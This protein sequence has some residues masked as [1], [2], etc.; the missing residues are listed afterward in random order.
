M[1]KPVLNE[2]LER[3][4]PQAFGAIGNG[5]VDDTTALFAAAK[6]ASEKGLVLELDGE[7]L[8]SQTL[9]LASVNVLSKNA[10]LVYVGE[11]KSVPA[12]DMIRN[13]NV[14]GTL[15]IDF[16]DNGPGNHGGRCAMGF[17]H[18]G[19]GRGGYD[20][21]VEHVVITG[22]QKDANG[23]LITGDSNNILFD[24][25]TV[26]FEGSANIGRA[27]LLH[28]GNANDHRVIGQWS[29]ENGYQHVDGWKPTKHPHNVR[30]GVLECY[31][32]KEQGGFGEGAFHIAAGYDV[33]LDELI[34]DGFKHAVMITG[35]DIGFEY[36]DPD[37]REIK[38]RN[39]KIGK[40]KATNLRGGS[41]VT[42]ISYALM[43]PEKSVDTE[44]EIGEVTATAAEG[45]RAYGFVT[46]CAKTLRIGKLELSGFTEKGIYVEKGNRLVEIGEATVIGSRSYAL[47]AL[48]YRQTS[49]RPETV[50]VGLL[51]LKDCRPTEVA[52]FLHAKNVGTL[53]IGT[54]TAEDS[55]AKYVA[56]VTNDFATVSIDEINGECLTCEELIHPSEALD[57]DRC[58]KIGRVNA[59][60]V[61]KV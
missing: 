42:V 36:A 61:K 49:P 23:I 3:I 53:A 44:L 31:N 11:T 8:Y 52:A 13:V 54:L 17:G 18:Y 15:H 10:K 25:I 39:L 33:E 12:V 28:W 9:E 27:L 35:G 43:Y 37:V 20:C 40:I 41:A 55:D 19:T 4:T 16:S 7:F 26:P 6:A 22:G 59:P 24:R 14:F 21:Y 51:T 5:Q 29:V 45:S 50:K 48:Q 1:N 2:S 34:V 46:H 38:Q 58:I 56:E 32:N 57:A 30:V 47:E 60:N